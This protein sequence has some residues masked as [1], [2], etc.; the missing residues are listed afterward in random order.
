MLENGR[1][2]RV[3]RGMR[4]K[5]PPQKVKPCSGSTQNEAVAFVCDPI[6]R[7]SMMWAAQSLSRHIQEQQPLPAFMWPGHSEDCPDSPSLLRS[8]GRTGSA[9]RAA[10]DLGHCHSPVRGHLLLLCHQEGQH[11]ARLVR[12]PKAPAAMAVAQQAARHRCDLK[13][14]T[15][16]RSAFG[17]A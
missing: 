5:C 17:E 7:G 9:H 6:Q 14:K 3:R 2:P 15:L 13:M 4:T 10:G 16:S 12:D 8:K 1:E 11:R